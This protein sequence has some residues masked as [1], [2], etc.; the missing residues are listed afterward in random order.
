M[1]AASAKKQASKTLTITIPAYNIQDYLDR[2]LTSIT[3]QEIIDELD[4]IIVND[5]S[6]D[7]TL[8][9]AKK[10]Q[11]KYPNSIRVIDKENGGHG[12][13]IN[14][15][16]AL[17]KGKYFRVLDGDDWFS[18]ATVLAYLKELKKADEDLILTNYSYVYVQQN[19]KELIDVYEKTKNI[20]K[21]SGLSDLEISDHDLIL[22]LAIHSCTIKTEQ[23][24]KVWGAGLLEKVFYE[25]Q[26]FVSKI[27][28]AADSMRVYDMDVYQYM[29][30][31]DEQTMSRDKMFKHRQDH[32]SVLSQLVEM[33]VNCSD[34]KKRSLLLRRTREIYKTHYWIYFYH[35]GL[36]RQEKAEFKKFK[37]NISKLDPEISQ[38]VNIKFKLQL[39]LGRHRAMLK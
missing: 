22:T 20:K 3:K 2:S 33:S 4:I 12:S 39:F 34:Q 23:L 6:K 5:G 18:D 21:V 31:R 16:M 17:A 36:T 32:A 24:Q 26:E 28:L 10:Y 15:A 7:K 25:D 27:I 8:D 11:E 9:I 37:A 14:T 1:K 29:I 38:K 35:P 30:G 19:K 13:V